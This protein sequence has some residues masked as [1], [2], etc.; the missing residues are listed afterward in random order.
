MART[1]LNP[2]LAKLN[3][4]YTT[5]EVARLYNL[6]RETVRRWVRFA[7]LHPID[8][9]RPTL[10]HGAT[11][12]TFV[13]ARREA[14]KRPTPAGRLHCFGCRAARRPALRMA[15][16]HPSRGRGAGN[17][18]A[19]CETCGGVMNRRARWEAVP[20]ILPGVEV[21]VMEGE[22]RIAERPTPPATVAFNEDENP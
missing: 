2:R 9:R 18:R 6:S 11:L 21:R 15:D 1:R 8:G 13:A 17:I 20:V 16:F 19:L 12:Q 4:T 14:A 5:E 7:G 3:R 22:G 10:I